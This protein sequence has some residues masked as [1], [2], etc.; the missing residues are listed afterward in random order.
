MCTFRCTYPQLKIAPNVYRMLRCN[1]PY[2]FYNCTVFGNV[3]SLLE[4]KQQKKIC[5]AV[6]WFSL[7]NLWRINNTT[8]Y[9]V[10]RTIRTRK[11]FCSP[12]DGVLFQIG[13][14]SF[15]TFV[16]KSKLSYRFLVFYSSFA[17]V[18]SNA[19]WQVQFTLRSCI[20]IFF[21][22]ETFRSKSVK[23]SRNRYEKEHTPNSRNELISSQSS[24]FGRQKWW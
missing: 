5:V 6:W 21:V 2:P 12:S 8:K 9:F 24:L 19:K 11:Y 14:H 23:Y 22:Y 10:I 3:A 1:N 18:W 13:Y 17:F 15:V 20:I 4:L 7:S 16:L